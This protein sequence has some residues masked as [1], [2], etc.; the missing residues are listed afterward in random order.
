MKGGSVGIENIGTGENAQN[1]GAYYNLAGQR[2][3]KPA[4]GSIF[5]HNGKKM[6]M[7]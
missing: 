4:K 6:I 2:I 1:A 7:K 5:I 3:A